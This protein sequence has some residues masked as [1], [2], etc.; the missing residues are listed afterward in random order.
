[1]SCKKNPTHAGPPLVW[2]RMDRMRDMV[3][4]GPRMTTTSTNCSNWRGAPGAGSRVQRY[5]GTSARALTMGAANAF[6]TMLSLGSAN[7]RPAC[8]TTVLTSGEAPG[9][10]S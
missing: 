8:S 1:M 7:A 2:G 9:P 4:G 5:R 10:G 6:Y 3:S